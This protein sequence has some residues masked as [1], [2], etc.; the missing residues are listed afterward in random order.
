M[1]VQRISANG[2]ISR[3]NT[4]SFSRK[5]FYQVIF[6]EPATPPCLFQPRPRF[7]L[8]YIHHFLTNIATNLW[9]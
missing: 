6:F 7:T 8:G 3:Y 1:G 5:Q 2:C 9:N 4:L